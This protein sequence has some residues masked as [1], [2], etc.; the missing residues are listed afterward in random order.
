MCKYRIP[1]YYNI[2]DQLIYA[3]YKQKYRFIFLSIDKT[4]RAH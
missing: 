4:V 3:A 2:P 1:A